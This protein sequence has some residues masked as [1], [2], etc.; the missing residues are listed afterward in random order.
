MDGM[1]VIQAAVAY[2]AVLHQFDSEDHYPF[3]WDDDRDEEN[4]HDDE[5]WGIYDGSRVDPSSATAKFSTLSM[6]RL[7]PR[8]RWLK[9]LLSSA[10]LPRLKEKAMIGSSYLGVPVAKAKE[11]QKVS[12][13]LS[14]KA[15]GKD[16]G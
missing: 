2:G 9:N 12:V 11:S 5:S 10:K 3:Y 8:S 16:K 7:P 4:Y 1:G 14:A 13:A 15:K 6:R